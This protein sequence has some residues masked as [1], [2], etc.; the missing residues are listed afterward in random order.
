MVEMVDCSWSLTNR[1]LRAVGEIE[2]EDLREP[3]PEA[4]PPSSA[5]EHHVDW[6]KYVEPAVVVVFVLLFIRRAGPAFL[7]L[8]IMLS[9]S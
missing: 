3:V 9:F 7:L 4:P 6:S 1:N 2:L 5:R 8:A